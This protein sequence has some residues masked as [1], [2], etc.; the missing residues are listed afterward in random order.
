MPLK[1]KKIMEL[2][3]SDKVLEIVKTRIENNEYDNFDEL[4]SDLSDLLTVFPKKDRIKALA[5]VG[6]V[7]VVLGVVAMLVM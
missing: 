6:A 5:V 1:L 3:V 7:V 2:E 4:L